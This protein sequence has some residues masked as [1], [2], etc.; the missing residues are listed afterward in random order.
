MDRALARL[1]VTL[2]GLAFAWQIAVWLAGLPP[3][4]LPGPRAVIEA[5]GLHGEVLWHDTLVTAA[6]V[7]MG[8]VL[9]CGLG[10]GTAL[11]IAAVRPARRWL[12]PVLIASQAVPV[13]ALA[14]I[15][16]L[17]FGYGM[18]SKVIMAALVIY[19]PVTASFSDGLRRTEPGWLDLARTMGASRRTMLWHVRVPA[20]LPALGSGLRL[21]ASFAPIGAV[22]GEWV[23]SSA[24]LGYRMV[25][26]NA[27][28][29]IDLL[30]AALIILA[31]MGVGLYYAVDSAV[32]T[33][34]R[35]QPDTNPTDDDDKTR[36]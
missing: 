13:F 12:L 8:L 15:L 20:A 19:F 4:I 33:V 7:A 6:E 10:I 25:Q 3:F 32:R 17:W 18:A 22:I 24:G 31:A 2:A 21:A 27:R 23:G 14:P 26:A 29:Q 9:G 28:L 35:W 34:V 11:L 5:F 30:F 16:V 1:V 36:S